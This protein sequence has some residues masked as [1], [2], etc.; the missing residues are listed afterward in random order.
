MTEAR[1]LGKQPKP[2]TT[3]WIK[4]GGGQPARCPPSPFIKKCRKSYFRYFNHAPLY[5]TALF[6]RSPLLLRRSAGFFFLRRTPTSPARSPPPH[7]AQVS[8]VP[9]C[10][11]C[12]SPSPVS[13]AS[14]MAPYTQAD[15][16]SALSL[17]HIWRRSAPAGDNDRPG[18]PPHRGFPAAPAR[19]TPRLSA[20]AG[21][22]IQPLYHLPYAIIPFYKIICQVT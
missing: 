6:R 9:P 1:Y 3:S 14:H 22:H 17:I 19:I 15:T 21:G 12:T 18:S 4:N 20:F 10:A 11:N 8:A 7:T 13:A 5:V 16:A 2:C